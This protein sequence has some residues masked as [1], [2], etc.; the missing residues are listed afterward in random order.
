MRTISDTI[1][2]LNK[3][4]IALSTGNSNKNGRLVQLTDFGTNPGQLH[5]WSY[6]PDT[7]ATNAPLVVVLHG[8]TQSASD[9]DIGSGW[10]KLAE[11]YGFAL[12]YPEQQRTNNPNLCFNWFSKND[13]RREDGEV[14]SIAQM[15]EILVKR[16]SL[17]RKRIYVTGLSAGGAMAAAMLAAY[18]EI[19]NSGAIVAGIAYGT[20]STIPQAF[21]R[22]RGHGLEDGASLATYVTQATSHQGPWPKVSVW[23]G[24]IDTTVDPVNMEAI[25]GQWGSLHGL[26]RPALKST[27]DGHQV[28]KWQNT[29]GETVLEAYT[30][31]GMGHGTPI[32][33]DGENALGSARPFM[34]DVG[35]SSTWQIAS[36]WHLLDQR[37]I[38]RSAKD[39]LDRETAAAKSTGKNLEAIRQGIESALK[40]A[41]LMR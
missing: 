15:I 39:A 14:F 1:K 40:S 21:D 10:S 24:S 5:A 23:H 6:M 28:R 7:L 31:A 41:G 36:S 33:S 9:Y 34:L 2:R 17:N 22:M 30:I 25:I 8:C 4:R 32:K 18:P 27:L 19:F 11:E 16:H 37:K 12:L 26:D 35:I 38:S 29:A 20:A 13:T 3:H